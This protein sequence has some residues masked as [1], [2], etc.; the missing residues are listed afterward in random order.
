MV[1]RNLQSTVHTP[2]IVLTGNRNEADRCPPHSDYKQPRSG[3]H[4]DVCFRQSQ[5]KTTEKPGNSILWTSTWSRENYSQPRSVVGELNKDECFS[6][7]NLCFPGPMPHACH[8]HPSQG[9]AQWMGHSTLCAGNSLLIPSWN[10]PGSSTNRPELAIKMD[11]FSILFPSPE[12]QG[13]QPWWELSTD[14]SEMP[15]SHLKGQMAPG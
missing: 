7:M 5:L 4:V 8:P 1:S 11:W 9:Q 12:N 6:H 14:S 13:K 2:G 10:S 3:G 15:C